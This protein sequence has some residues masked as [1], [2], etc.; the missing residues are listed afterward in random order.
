M[1]LAVSVR[2][3]G[4]LSAL[5]LFG[6]SFISALISSSVPFLSFLGKKPISI[7]KKE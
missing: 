3:F 1:G 7:M 2:F 6:L 5:I 4:W